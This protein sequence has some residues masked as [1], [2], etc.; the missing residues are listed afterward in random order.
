MITCSITQSYTT[1][2]YLYLTYS[3]SSEVKHNQ[4]NIRTKSIR[5]K[6]LKATASPISEDAVAIYVLITVQRV[7]N[8]K[9]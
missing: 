1:A 2:F 6:I 5:I 7:S 8:I 9:S 3:D 4:V